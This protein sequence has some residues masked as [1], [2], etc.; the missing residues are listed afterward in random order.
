MDCLYLDNNSTTPLLPAVA[1][2]MRPFLGGV[3]GNP[4]SAH[5]LG[6]QAR[7]A[8]EDAREQVAALLDTFPDEVFF[9]SGAT[10]ANNLAIRSQESGVRSQQNHLIASPIEHPSVLEPLRHLAQNGHALSW[11]GVDTTGVVRVEELPALLRDDTGLVAVMLANHETGAIQPVR[12]VVDACG[13]VP[14]HCDAVQAVGKIAVHFHDLGVTSLAL[15]AHK[16]HGPKGVGALLVRR[17]TRLTPLL[18]GGHQQHGL[19]PGTE[20]VAAIVG[21]AAALALADRDR[22]S[23]LAHVRALRRRFLTG[24]DEAAPVL[25]G[26]AEDGIPHTLNLSFPGLKADL[27][28]MSLDLAGVCCSTGSACSSGSLLPSPVLQA[29]NVPDDRLRSALRFSLSPLLSEA[30]IDEAA[31]RICR[32]V[33]RLRQEPPLT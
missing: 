25:N 32:V 19:R 12:A 30:D 26:P 29:M 7:Q 13:E 17:G 18:R 33:K 10:E 31:A 1:D 23:R 22:A 6:R 20:P 11:L 16:F 9:T 27:L 5:R 21:L 15:S 2:A 14:V 4:S 3:Y 28:L 8:L 24:L